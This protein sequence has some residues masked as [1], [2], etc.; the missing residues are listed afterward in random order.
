MYAIEMI[1]IKIADANRNVICNVVVV[2]E[3]KS[4]SMSRK[5]F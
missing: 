2:A 5:Y 1:L 3:P 4:H